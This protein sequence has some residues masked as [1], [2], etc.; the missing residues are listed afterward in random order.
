MKVLYLGTDPSHFQTDG[1]LMHYPVIK[2]VPRPFQEIKLF[3]D[4]LPLY[5][6]LIF[7]SKNAVEI[8]FNYGYLLPPSLIVIAVGKVT[9]QYVKADFVA[10]DETQEGIIDILKQCDL[11]NAYIF[12]PRSSLSR[13]ALVDFFKEHNIRYATCDLYD[14]L[15]QKLEP[16]PDLSEIDEIV[17]TSPSTVDA[18]LQIY[19]SLP[20][21]KKLTTIGPITELRVKKF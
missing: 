9:A 11:K 19:G 8:F 5:T 4:D 12:Y 6:H 7:T 13:P 16:V 18:F 14:T 17:F 21:N 15:A 2:I 10:Q 3:F 20:Q 1:V